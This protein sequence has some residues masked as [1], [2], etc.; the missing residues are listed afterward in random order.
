[1]SYQSRARLAAV[2]PVGWEA[3]ERRNR[4]EQLELADVSLAQLD[5]VEE[6]SEAGRNG[7]VRVPGAVHRMVDDKAEVASGPAAALGFFAFRVD[8]NDVA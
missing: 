3:D 2:Q 5:G 7:R 6:R 1:M 8:E 4:P